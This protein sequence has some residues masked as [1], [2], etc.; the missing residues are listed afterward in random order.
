VV[1]FPIGSAFLRTEKETVMNISLDTFMVAQTG[2]AAIALICLWWST[3]GREGMFR[4][5]VDTTAAGWVGTALAL[6]L[7][8]VIRDINFVAC[9][10]VQ[11]G[12][13]ATGVGLTLWDKRQQAKASDDNEV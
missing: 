10:L 13:I 8:L 7:M 5:L 3:K 9:L 12:I 6:L 4:P 11:V 2:L 1:L